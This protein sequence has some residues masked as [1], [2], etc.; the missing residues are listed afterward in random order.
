VSFVWR[1]SFERVPA[2]C[3]GSLGQD[4]VPDGRSFGHSCSPGDGQ[5]IEPTPTE[6]WHGGMIYFNP[7]D[8]AI[9]VER[10]DSVGYTFNFANTWSWILLGS[11]LIP[12]FSGHVFLS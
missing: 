9:I 7:N 11:F 10:R 1:A 3:T 12:S 4:F 2:N 8:P 5:P 6:C